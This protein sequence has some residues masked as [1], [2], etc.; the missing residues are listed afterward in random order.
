MYP[1]GTDGPFTF[2]LEAAYRRRMSSLHLC[3]RGREMDYVH[4]PSYSVEAMVSAVEEEGDTPFDLDLEQ[5]SV[6]EAEVLLWRIRLS[7]AREA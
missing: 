4:V 3:Q 6:L 5:R 2:D 7:R 1:N